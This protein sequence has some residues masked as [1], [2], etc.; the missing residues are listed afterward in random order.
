MDVMNA[1]EKDAKEARVCGG[2]PAVLKVLRTC[3]QSVGYTSFNPMR[4]SKWMRW[5]DH[6]ITKAPILC[7]DYVVG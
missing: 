2:Q 5:R 7:S 1:D 4:G 6:H 3:Q